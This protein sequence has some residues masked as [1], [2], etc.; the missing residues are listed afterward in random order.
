MK[1]LSKA[2]SGDWIFLSLWLIQPLFSGG[3]TDLPAGAVAS[4]VL[5]SNVFFQ[6]SQG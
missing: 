2:R 4:N 6:H 5:P 1:P 3:E